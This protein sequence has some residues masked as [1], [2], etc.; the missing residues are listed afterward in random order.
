M[1]GCRFPV[2]ERVA[3]GI[4]YRG[5]L[6]EFGWAGC[7]IVAYFVAT[8]LDEIGRGVWGLAMPG[9]VIMVLVVV[10]TAFFAST[11][12]SF[13]RPV[14]VLLLLVMI[15]LATT[16]LG[17]DSWVTALMTPVLAKF[18]TNAGAWLLIYTSAI[19]FVL[20]FFAG[21]IV[22]RI[23]PVGLLAVC[24]VLAAVGLFWIAK[25]GPVAWSIFLAA[26]LYGIGKSF[27]WPTTLGVVSEQFPKGGA[28]TLNAMGGM[29]MIAVGVLGNPLL[30]VIQDHAF[31]RTLQTEHP[32][33]HAKAAAEQ[34]SKFGLTFT[35]IDKQKIGNLP[36]AER[37]FVEQVRN[38]NN[39][40]TLAKMAILPVI[41]A[42]CYAGL[43]LYYRS[44]GGYKSVNLHVRP[45]PI[46]HARAPT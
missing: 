5:M 40:E 31:D 39:Q 32:V 3:A 14:F 46:D 30:G 41:M 9:W 7:L 25:A 15:L 29:G 28:L 33:L 19:M 10:P 23:S 1:V 34:Q 18:G 43:M 17:T 45:G 11:V 38:R 42:V 44:R 36:A 16:E 2:Q 24:S 8:G 4:S 22:H 20:R 27:F 13:G 6:R 21:P 12:R 26:T 35:P 37:E